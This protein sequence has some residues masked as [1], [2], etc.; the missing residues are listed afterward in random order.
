MELRF[1]SRSSTP[2]RLPLR[3]S[4]RVDG[5]LLGLQ[6]LAPLGPRLVSLNELDQHRHRARP[7]QDGVLDY[8]QRHDLALGLV[9]GFAREVDGDRLIELP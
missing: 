3:S 7:L 4:T 2:V 9:D 1:A 8:L 6:R 5:R